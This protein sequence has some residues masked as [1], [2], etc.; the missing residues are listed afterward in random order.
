MDVSA[1]ADYAVRALLVL[2]E[3]AEDGPVHPAEQLAR[4]AGVPAKF[5]EAIL[6]DLR[7]A[8]FVTSQ[9]GSGGGYRL[10]RDPADI[11]LGAVLRAVDGPLAEVRGIRPHETSYSGAAEHLATVWVAARAAL[12]EV[13]DETTLADVLR[14][15]LPEHVRAMAAAPDAW[16]GR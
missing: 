3:D 10:A 9:R 13:L 5:L 1:R 14:G 6:A 7:R 4:R 15:E 8:G 2:A 16:R 12:R 11:P